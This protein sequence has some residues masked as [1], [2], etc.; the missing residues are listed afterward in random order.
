L[1]FNYINAKLKSLSCFSRFPLRAANLSPD[2][3]KRLAPVPGRANVKALVPPPCPRKLD[4]LPILHLLVAAE[5]A[6]AGTAAVAG[7]LPHPDLITRS[8]ERREAVLSSQIEGTRTDLTQ[9]LEYEAT[10]AAEGLPDDAEVTLSYVRALDH[11]LHA[12]RRD[13]G[14]RHL[15]L[16]LIR[17]LHRILMSGADYRHPEGPGEWRRVQNW[18]GG[19]RIED[20][21]L[22]PPPVS[23]LEACLLD[24]EDFLQVDLRSPAMM[25]LP[26]RMAVAHVQF[27]AIHPFS[28]GNGRVGRLLPPLMMSAEGLPPLYLAGYLKTHQRRYYDSL[29][30]V[31]LRG[32]WVEWLE[33]FLEGVAAAAATEQATAQSLL[34]VRQDWQD[35]TRHMRADAAA[36]RLLDVL[37]GAPVQTVASAREALGTSVQAAN[38][39]IAALLDLDIIREATG[40][41]WGRSFQAHEILAVLDGRGVTRT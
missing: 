14:P 40:R 41:R 19:R 15:T 28:D 13:D 7:L 24:L 12:V 9:L 22:I 30:G 38:T 37:L 27:E 16:D 29:A 6:I 21:T 5:R 11:G 2:R 32:R 39:G 26:L 17:Q 4:A 20:A 18:I 34:A 36:R 23:H 3:R 10:G 35:R 1:L 8:L 33:F 25:A 31:Q